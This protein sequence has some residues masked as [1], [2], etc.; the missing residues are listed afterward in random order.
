MSGTSGV[1][2]I[3]GPTASGK[4]ELAI[5]LARTFGAE[6]VNA[7]SRQIYRGMPVGTAAPTAQQLAAVPHHLFGFLDPAQRYSAARYSADA[8]AAVAQIHARG[9]RAIVVGGT[10]FYVRALTGAVDLAPQYDEAVRERLVREARLHDADFLHAWLSVRDRARAA[11]IHPQDSYRVLRALEVALAPH[12]GSR[13][14]RITSLRSAG[15]PFLKIFLAVDQNALRE[16]IARRTD[17]M[18]RAGFVEEAERIGEDAVAASAVGYPQALAYARG[19]ST[20][21]ELRELLIRATRRYSKRQT[22]WFRS[23]PEIVGALPADVERLA[24]ESLQWVEA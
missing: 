10:G 3:A 11:A 17:A 23:E 1:L 9:K 21:E 6:I 20:L 19:W 24:R 16:R 2:V 13:E 22:T 15:I 4:T 14:G 5:E 12:S 8:V 18:L 7:D